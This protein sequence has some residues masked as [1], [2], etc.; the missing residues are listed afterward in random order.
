MGNPK[1]IIVVNKI[2][3]A[4]VSY[5]FYTQNKNVMTIMESYIVL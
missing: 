1:V 3:Y 2:K 5:V 4:I